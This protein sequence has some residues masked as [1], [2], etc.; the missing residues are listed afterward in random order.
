MLAICRAAQLTVET[1]S[2]FAGQQLALCRDACSACE[3]ECAPHKQHHDTC[4]ACASACREAMDAID[5]LLG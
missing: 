1:H 5:R 2:S 4:R 3:T